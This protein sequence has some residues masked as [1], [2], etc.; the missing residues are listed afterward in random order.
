MTR[1]LKLLIVFTAVAT[2]P[3][4]FG[5]NPENRDPHG[6]D[7]GRQVYIAEGCIHCHSQYIRPDSIDEALWGDAREPDFSR[8]QNP[9]LIG[10][11][12]Q[13]PDLMNVGLRR[14]REWQRKHLRDP[15]EIVPTSRMPSYDHLF[16]LDE[17]RGEA[18]LDYLDSLGRESDIAGP[19]NHAQDPAAN[20]R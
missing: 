13:G 18:L 10:N 17:P 9:A 1:S 6:A 3:F 5:H 11:R 19:N 12:R 20:P 15:R 16:S 7:F 4:L 14:T 2:L 8:Y